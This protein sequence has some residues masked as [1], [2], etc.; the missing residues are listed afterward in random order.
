MRLSH[1]ENI[2][3]TC[4]FA[5]Q[6]AAVFVDGVMLDQVCGALNHGSDAVTGVCPIAWAMQC[7][8][9]FFALIL[10]IFILCGSEAHFIETCRADG[11]KLYLSILR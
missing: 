5:P 7:P 3:Y 10:F 8:G 2:V 9:K 1:A 6:C 4:S 11:N